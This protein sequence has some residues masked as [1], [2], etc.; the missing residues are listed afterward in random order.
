MKFLGHLLRHDCLEN[1]VP[2]GKIHGRRAKGRQRVKFAES[3]VEDIHREMT[4]AEFTTTKVAPSVIR[5]TLL[6]E[7]LGCLGSIKS[8]SHQTQNHKNAGTFMFLPKRSGGRIL[9]TNQFFSSTQ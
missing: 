6:D 8:I 9:N 3:L 4:V 1:V 7:E 5:S 2:L